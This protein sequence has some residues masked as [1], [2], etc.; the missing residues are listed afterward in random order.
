MLIQ[1]TKVQKE[2]SLFGLRINHQQVQPIFINCSHFL[3][4]HPFHFPGNTGAATC[5]KANK[6][7]DK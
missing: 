3:L 6:L 7:G 1:A 4:A 5:L 2:R